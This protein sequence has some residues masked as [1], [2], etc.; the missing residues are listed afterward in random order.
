LM[1]ACPIAYYLLYQWLAD[2]HLRTELN[3]TVFGVP[4]VSLLVIV[5]LF[6]SLQCVRAVSANPVDSLRDE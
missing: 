6:I 1:L 4:V 5:M 3:V 2:F